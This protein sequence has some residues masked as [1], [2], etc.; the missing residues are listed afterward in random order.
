MAPGDELDGHARRSPDVEQRVDEL[1]GGPG[2]CRP[3]L[4]QVVIRAV[5]RR[6]G[7]R[8]ERPGRRGLHVGV[9]PLHRPQRVAVAG[10]RRLAGGAGQQHRV[11]DEAEGRRVATD[12]L[13]LV[14]HPAH[15]LDELLG[16][17]VR[18]D[19][20]GEACGAADRGLRAAADERP[21]SASTASAGR[22]ASG[23]R[24]PSPWCVNGSPVHAC[25]RI[26]RISSM[27]APRRR[28]SAPSPTNST[29][30][31]AEPEAQD[32]PA[33]AE[34]LD[35]R[36][37]LRQA[38]RVVHRC[39]D[40]AGAELDA[41]RRLRERRADDEERGHV[42]VIDEV[43]LG[44]PD[45]REAEP[46]RLDGQA[47]RLVVGTRPV[48]LARPKLRAEQSEAE[49]HGRRRYQP[50]P[51]AAGARSDGPEPVRAAP[52]PAELACSR[53]RVRRVTRSACPPT[54]ERGKAGESALAVARPLRG[55]AIVG[56]GDERDD[57]VSERRR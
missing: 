8:R 31:P 7:R 55:E 41:R 10:E 23:G 54:S 26:R 50:T 4:D 33:V 48:G 14:E 51:L 35:G 52:A 45:G 30:G 16:G 42:A 18:E 37:V 20:I 47:D 44:R 2:V 32:Q 12:P 3:A 17:G 36:R 38:Q 22:R 21:G 1:V 39:E 9:L 57:D 40:D 13:A 19:P 24:R 27:A 5:E 28:A 43:V 34:Q 15:L 6:R 29:S 46:L 56:L 49:S 11:V 53:G 25:G